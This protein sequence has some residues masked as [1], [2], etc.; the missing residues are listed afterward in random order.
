MMM[1]DIDF[2]DREAEDGPTPNG[3]D[4]APFDIIDPTT[5]H[6]LPV[7]PRLWLVPDWIPMARV[8]ALYGA[9]GEGKTLLGQ[10][11][12]TACAI[13][14]PWLGLRV[15]RCN[16]LLLFAEDDRDE[17][18]ARQ[19]DINALYGCTFADLGAM[20][21]LPR[22]G[23]DCELMT[24]ESGR[25]VRTPLFDRLL[26]HAREHDAQLIETDT[27]SDVFSGN[28]NDRAQVRRFGRLGL[29]HLAH[30]TKAAVLAPAHPSLTGI[31]RGTGDSASTGWRGTFRSQLYLASPKA[32]EDTPSDPDIRTLSRTKANWAR[33]DETIEIRW[34]NGVFAPLHAAT[35]IIASIEKRTGERV[36]GDLLDHTMS[37]G[38]RVSHNSRSG[39]YAPK[40]FAMHPNRERFTKRDFEHAMHA[41]LARG[42]IV[43]EPY[44]DAYRNSHEALARAR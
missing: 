28:E 38:Q 19:E 23:E 10:M 44:K 36:F 11:L 37:K 25:A 34:Q 29:G 39:N 27:L 21:W 31:A 40:I 33:R 13:G 4:N 42:E 41:L 1:P 6:G 30:A 22:L 9:G 32:E 12:A 43:I 3:H 16:S 2:I 35:G 20:R 17:M 5:L 18:H 15:R 8:T 24:F 26:Q 14:Q 7:P